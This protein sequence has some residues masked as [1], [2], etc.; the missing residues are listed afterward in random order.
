MADLIPAKRVLAIAAGLAILA[1]AIYA[2]GRMH[3]WPGIKGSAAL[4]LSIGPAAP[5]QG[6]PVLIAVAGTSTAAVRSVSLRLPGKTA[7]AELPFFAY[8][9]GTAALYGISLGQKTGVAAVTVALAD[10]QALSGSFAIAS[11]SRPSESLPIPP[12][13]GG[14]SAAN[15]ARVVDQLAIDNAALARIFSDGRAAFWTE[16]FA[17]PVASSS[18][19]Q[20]KVTDPY[21]YERDSGAAD[22]IHKGADFRAPP[23]TPVYAVNDGVV[24]QARLYPT[25]GN[26]V[27]IDH[28]MGVLSMYMHLSHMSVK[29]GVAVKRGEL[30]GLSGETGYAEGPHL[31]LTI[32]IN[33]N[34]IDPIAFFQLFGLAPPA[35]SLP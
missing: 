6:D 25:Y 16:P 26:T 3:I 5:L 35:G 23:G 1:C 24:R 21:G 33:G 30:I 34:S 28:G 17:F 18:G 7:P 12:Q 27:V 32:R 11:R 15:Q 13:I 14:N 20:R 4:S 19:D 31:H 29:P 9:G 22:I 10:G 2:A 8:G